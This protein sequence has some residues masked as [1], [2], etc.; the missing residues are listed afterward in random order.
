LGPTAETALE[1]QHG[2]TG[3][4]RIAMKGKVVLKEVERT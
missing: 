2:K 3:A 4:R 1:I